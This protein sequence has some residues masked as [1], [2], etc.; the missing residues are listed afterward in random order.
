MVGIREVGFLPSTNSPN[1]RHR[2]LFQ[3]HSRGEELRRVP[4]VPAGVGA[5]IL[6]SAEIGRCFRHSNKEPSLVLDM[7][8]IF[9]GS[10]V[11]QDGSDG[12]FG[13]V[14]Q[15]ERVPAKE[16]SCIFCI[17]KAYLH[18]L[19]EPPPSLAEGEAMEPTTMASGVRSSFGMSMTEVSRAGPSKE[20]L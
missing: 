1:M 10:G 5:P 11:S 9:K 14:K 3:S 7:W 12:H 13:H 20:A 2:P 6:L 16:R 15:E 17:R 4:R 8:S 19:W 18:R